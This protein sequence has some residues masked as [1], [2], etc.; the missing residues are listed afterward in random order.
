V[1]GGEESAVKQ[2]RESLHFP[3][4]CVNALCIFISAK[5]S[6]PLLFM[7]IEGIELVY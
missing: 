5:K 4:A 1:E 6:E 3:Q 7:G 2:V